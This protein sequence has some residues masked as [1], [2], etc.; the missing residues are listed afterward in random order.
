MFVGFKGFSVRISITD[1]S[2]GDTISIPIFDMS[3]DFRD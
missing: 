2:F 1:V 3:A